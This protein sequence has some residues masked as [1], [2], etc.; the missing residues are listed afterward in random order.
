MS[1][2]FAAVFLTEKKLGQEKQK[3]KEIMVKI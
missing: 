2:K 1:V 3:N